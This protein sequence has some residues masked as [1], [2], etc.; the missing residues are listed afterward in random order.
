MA[1]TPGPINTD[2]GEV[3]ARALQL[4]IEHDPDPPFDSGSF[5]TADPETKRRATAHMVPGS[6]HAQAPA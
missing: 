2:V 1:T 5:E 6:E 4:V 3:E